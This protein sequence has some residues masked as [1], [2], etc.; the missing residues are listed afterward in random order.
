MKKFIH[1]PVEEL[2]ARDILSIKVPELLFTPDAHEIA[3]RAKK[4]Q[5]A[6]HPDRAGRDDVFKHISQLKDHAERYIKAGL[7]EVP[8][9]ISFTDAK[10]RK[11]KTFEHVKKHR[12]ELGEMYIA[13]DKVI[14][15]VAKRF[16]DLFENAREVIGSIQYPPFEKKDREYIEAMVPH[17]QETIA[18]PERDV[19]VVEKAPNLVLL[20][21]LQESFGGVMDSKQA[22]WPLSRLHHIACL[23]SFNKLAHNGIAT[24]TLFVGPED[25]MGALLGGWWYTVKHGSALIGLPPTTVEVVPPSML[26]SGEADSRVDLMLI[27]AA[28]RTMLGD[29]TGMKL[30]RDRKV[31]KPLSDWLTLP[32]DDNARADQ[33]AWETLLKSGEMGPRKF[34]P[35]PG[36][37]D[38]IYNNQP[39]TR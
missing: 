28:G 5:L 22:V 14:F 15:A 34:T 21:D 7:W 25:H 13:R 29:K 12:F 37:F 3:A 38:S 19:M 32:P 18:T 20:A 24:N 33:K 9:E 10:T 1:T 6:W 17:I 2:T 8:G 26:E 11:T 30:P 39:L 16:K 31:P 35:T 4:L 27:R 23:T 36:S